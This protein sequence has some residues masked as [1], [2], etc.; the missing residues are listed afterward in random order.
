ASCR[1]LVFIVVDNSW[2]LVKTEA[3]TNQDQTNNGLEL[4]ETKINSEDNFK[5]F[6]S[7]VIS[8]ETDIKARKGQAWGAFQ[9]L[10]NIFKSKTP[11]KDTGLYFKLQ[12][13]IH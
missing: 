12:K 7:M 1:Y 8:S 5:Y 2:P 6:G 3:L 9:K 11:T 13:G 4:N 10:K